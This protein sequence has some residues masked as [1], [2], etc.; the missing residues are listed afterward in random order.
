M[1]HLGD[2]WI[3]YGFLRQRQHVFLA[4][5]LTQAEKSPDAEEHDL[6]VRSLK[7]AEFEEM[8]RTGVIGDNCTV[9]AWGLYLLWKSQHS[10]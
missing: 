2:L 7:I 5:G 8:M 6:I 1:T 10:K 3:A 9:S 4:S